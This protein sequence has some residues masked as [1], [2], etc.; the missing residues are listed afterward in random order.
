MKKLLLVVTAAVSV[1]LITGCV[2]EKEANDIGVRVV[3]VPG[4]GPVNCV[5]VNPLNEDGVAVSC[6]WSK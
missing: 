3:Q 1:V 2:P 4:R 6:D 5:V